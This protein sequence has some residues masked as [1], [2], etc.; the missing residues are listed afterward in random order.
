MIDYSKLEVCLVDADSIC[1][2]GACQETLE[3]C[4][5]TID[6]SIENIMSNTNY[7]PLEIWVEATKDKLIFRKHVAVTRPYKGNRQTNP[8]VL[9]LKEAKQYIV[10]KHGAKVTHNYEAEDMVLIRA[11]EVGLDKVI[12][13]AIDKDVYQEAT[14][15]FN[16]YSNETVTL[17][18]G[19]ALS[20][21]YKQIL[22]GD[23]TDNIVGVHRLGKATA[24]KLIGKY[25]EEDEMAEAVAQ[26][27]AKKG[28]SY[29]YLIEQARLVY[30]LRGRQDVYEFPISE[31]RYYEEFYNA[32]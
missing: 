8:N 3:E 31:T 10:E 6:K 23:L 17:S 32:Y 7:I 25:M 9:W 20:N 27:Y 2:R 5:E 26:V 14:N 24:A 16:Y 12:V 21:L 22:T 11:N 28:Y 4:Y 30:I 19:E 29:H 13:A 1:Y 15:Y 18:K